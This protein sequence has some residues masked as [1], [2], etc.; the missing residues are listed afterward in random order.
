MAA[1]AITQQMPSS[2][3]D[4]E[5]P[6]DM[7]INVASLADINIPVGQGFYLR[8]TTEGFSTSTVLPMDIFCVAG[9]CTTVATIP[10]QPDGTTVDYYVFTSGDAIAP[11]TDGSDADYRTINADTNGGANFSYTTNVALPFTY[12]S[13]TGQ[14]LKADVVDLAWATASEDQ[15]S[16]FVVECSADAGY[17]WMDRATVSAQ[18]RPDGATYAFT[19]HDAPVV[20]LNYRLRQTDADGSFQYSNII[21]VPALHGLVRI[22]PQPAAGDRVN[23][24]VPDQYLGGEAIL[25][26]TVGR[27]LSAFP[28]SATQQEFKVAGLPAWMY[29][30]Q[31]S[32]P[33]GEK[34]VRRVIVR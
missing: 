21:P 33:D 27:K 8:Y 17:T 19:D 4:G 28:L 29:L 32:A 20:D 2:N 5:V 1:I 10:G 24:S 9:N 6:S 26:N 31:L 14:R 15:A 18:N 34:A 12:T 16:H 23:L 3:G 25:I 22:W 13:F 30:L 7:D 11:A